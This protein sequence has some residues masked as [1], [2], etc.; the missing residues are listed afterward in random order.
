[1]LNAVFELY[2]FQIRVKIQ[3]S[4]LLF[5]AKQLN[6][7]CGKVLY[8]NPNQT[9]IAEDTRCHVLGNGCDGCDNEKKDGHED[10]KGNFTLLV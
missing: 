8:S 3:M 2:P 5:S 6:I 4:L 10:E 1:V 7:S 9:Y